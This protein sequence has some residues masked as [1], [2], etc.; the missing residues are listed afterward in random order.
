[1]KCVRTAVCIA[2][3]AAI[4]SG[5]YGDDFITYT[6]A[7]RMIEVSCP[8]LDE[9]HAAVAF[10]PLDAA[11]EFGDPPI[12]FGVRGSQTSTL[13]ERGFSARG[14]ATSFTP[15]STFD[16]GWAQSKFEVT[17]T[18]DETSAFCLSGF[19]YGNGVYSLSGPGLDIEDMGW[20]IQKSGDL[21][22]DRIT[23]P[24]EYTFHIWLL[25]ETHVG[26]EEPNCAISEFQLDLV[27][28]P[29][30][31]AD[32]VSTE[33]PGHWDGRVDVLDLLYVIGNWGACGDPCF[34]DITGPGGEPDG[35]VDAMD[36]LAV[37]LDWG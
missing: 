24:G 20:N 1:M 19:L 32:V 4:A 16:Y 31:I 3:G 29:A 12:T 14:E 2:V 11:C 28:E 25:E 10:E 35:L 27:L 30:R 26:T 13:D 37:I 6:S 7:D 8:Y 34:A 5:A 23:G 17:L 33:G 22:C 36:F 18:I 9:S 15:N 21:S